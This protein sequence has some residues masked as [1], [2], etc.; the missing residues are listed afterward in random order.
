[1]NPLLDRISRELSVRESQGLLRAIP[2]V[3]NKP[4]IDLSTNSYLSLHRN[5]SVAREAAKL[6]AGRYHGNAASR[7]VTETS[8]LA[9]VLESE[10]ADWKEAE[11][12]LLFNSGYAANVGILQAIATRDTE[13]F[14]DRLNHASIIDGVRLS[15]CRLSRYR[16][17]DISDLRARLRAT[18]TKEK[19]IVT[20]TVFSMD[21]DCAPLADICD[22][23]EKYHCL[24][25]ADEA[26]ATG[27][28]GV[29]GGGLAE[30]L[31]VADRIDIRMGT[32]SKAVAGLGGY[33]AGSKLMKNYL[34]NGARSFIYST[35]LPH[36]VLAF[37]LAAVRHIRSH[38]GAGKALLAV[39]R[40][41][42][43]RIT[44]EGF[45]TLSS[46]SQIIP[47]MAGDQAAVMRLQAF[48]RNEGIV[49]P[50]IRP[51]TVPVGGARIRFSVYHGFSKSNEDAVVSA[52]R[53]WGVYHGA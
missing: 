48:L 41:F 33:F 52:L 3:N 4:V 50:A 24:V 31:G 47:V 30:A 2:S 42:R 45:N 12:A 5:A 29:S 34:I 39:A 19:I 27:V 13:V 25:M 10:I 17:C 35:S 18:K 23:A 49:A 22:L 36:A 32:L 51:P 16:H 11:S 7:L 6:V 26:H 38:S 53:R 9:A 20:D 46:V 1:M 15:G 8:P 28:F 43:E 40:R 14:C 37:D 21:G 44:G